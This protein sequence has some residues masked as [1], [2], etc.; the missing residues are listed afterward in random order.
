[1][2]NVIVMIILTSNPNPNL[3]LIQ[4]VVFDPTVL[5]QSN[6]YLLVASVSNIMSHLFDIIFSHFLN[7]SYSTTTDNNNDSD[8]ESHSD[9]NT[10]SHSTTDGTN[11]NEI[12]H[13]EILRLTTNINQEPLISA[14]K[15]ILPPIG[16]ECHIEDLVQSVA[17]VVFIQDLLHINSGNEYKFSNIS[18]IK[19]EDNSSSV[20]SS[21][22]SSS[23]GCN[24]NSNDNSNNNNDSN[25]SGNDNKT[26]K[27]LGMMPDSHS[28]AISQL[29][30]IKTVSLISSLRLESEL[31]L[32]LVVHMFKIRISKPNLQP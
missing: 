13:E 18:S 8:S 25:I 4:A 5:S 31:E 10:N 32:G 22:S 6:D 9:S 12:Q 26:N 28:L 3:F 19:N 23:G 15:L 7:Q 14:L 2:V 1:M 17:S 11:I 24:S 21:S 20:G 27:E 16:V 29:G 30:M